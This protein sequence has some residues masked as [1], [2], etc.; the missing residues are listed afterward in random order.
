[1]FYLCATTNSSSSKVHF[2]REE[3][4]AVVVFIYNF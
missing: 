4:T 1:M 2:G 3:A